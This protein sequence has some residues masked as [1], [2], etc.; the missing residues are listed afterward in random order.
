MELA[1]E[2]LPDARMETSEGPRA[3]GRN[4]DREGSP[5]GENGIVTILTTRIY[6]TPSSYLRVFHKSPNVAGKK[7]HPFT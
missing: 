7:R 6:E 1:G 3:T 4:R 2:T 5:T